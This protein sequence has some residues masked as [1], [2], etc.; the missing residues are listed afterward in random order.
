MAYIALFD[1]ADLLNDISL[2]NLDLV[3]KDDE[4]GEWVETGEVLL[5]DG[6]L[7][8]LM[9]FSD[10]WMQGYQNG[11]Y[12]VEEA[13]ELAKLEKPE[14]QK[15]VAPQDEEG[16]FLISTR[17]QFATYRYIASERNANASAKLMNDIDM[18]GVAM[19]PFGHN[20]SGENAV[21]I[22]RGDLDG[23]GHTLANVYIDESRTES[24]E[25]ATLFY[26]LK[27][28]TVKNL[29]LT[30]EYFNS[31]AESFMGGLTRWTSES[32][33][34]DNCEIAV[35]MHSYKQGDGTHGGVVGVSGT[36]TVINNCLVNVTMIG[37]A[38][39]PT[40]QCGGVCGWAASTPTITNTLILSKYENITKGVNGN[41]ISRNGY[42]A[43]NVY[44]VQSATGPTDEPFDTGG[45]LA[46]EG[47]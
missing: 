29:R 27:G 36:G 7:S 37:E 44:Y 10:D 15:F 30:G 6:E 20:R 4:S 47:T 14:M 11:T 32:S 26:E 19:K 3:E 28:S 43:S 16:N 21:H 34:V 41:V 39:S 25:P 31:R 12:S 1:A 18:V 8:A 42:N 17:E 46:T 45:T 5:D 35:V 13:S 40:Y 24:G 23:Q 9:D 33:T 38:E 22:Y 2:A